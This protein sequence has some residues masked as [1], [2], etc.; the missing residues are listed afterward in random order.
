ML[1]PPDDKNISSP[2]CG[3]DNDV[4]SVVCHVAGGVG[5]EVGVVDHVVGNVVLYLVVVVGCWPLGRC[6][7]S[8]SW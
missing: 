1:P 3:V 8:R 5:H 4:D 6:S 2:P 7:C